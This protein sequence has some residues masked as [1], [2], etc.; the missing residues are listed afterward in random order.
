MATHDLH[1]VLS[2]A[3]HPMAAADTPMPLPKQAP[4]YAIPTLQ[5]M[6]ATVPT[7][8]FFPN[9]TFSMQAKP[10]LPLSLLDFRMRLLATCVPE[11][12]LAHHTPAPRRPVREAPGGRPR[13]DT[14][15]VAKDWR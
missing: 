13:L 9:T 11:G 1:A 6:P 7:P 15:V 3:P 5:P 14:E 10:W 4:Q 12:M 8:V 2:C